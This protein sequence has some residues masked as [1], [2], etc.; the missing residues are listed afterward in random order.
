[1][2][3]ILS[4]Y[5]GC[6]K[7]NL[8]TN[9]VVWQKYTDRQDRNYIPRTTPPRGWSEIKSFA[10]VSKTTKRHEKTWARYCSCKLI[11]GVLW[12]VNNQA[13]RRD[14]QLTSR[15]KMCSNVVGRHSWL[16]T[17][18]RFPFFFLSLPSFAFFILFPSPFLC[19]PSFSLLFLLFL[20]P[21]FHPFS[22]LPLSFIYLISNSVPLFCLSSPL[23]PSL[24]LHSF[25]SSIMRNTC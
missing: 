12:G 9:V 16:W 25:S 18:V 6:A 3:H 11:L 15:E 2:T 24:P 1:M 4:R 20:S 8:L 5:T 23:D 21:C 22:I 19:L 17:S 14:G 13:V 10:H 7:T